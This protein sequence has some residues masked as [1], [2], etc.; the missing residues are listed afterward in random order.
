[1]PSTWPPTGKYLLCLLLHASSCLVSQCWASRRVQ[2]IWEARASVSLKQ[3][4]WSAPEL[5]LK[6]LG[7]EAQ[8]IKF[9]ELASPVFVKRN[10]KGM[11]LSHKAELWLCSSW[12]ML[13]LCNNF[14]KGLTAF[15][16]REIL[17]FIYCCCQKFAF[18]DA[19]L[20]ILSHVLTSVVSFPKK[21]LHRRVKRVNMLNW[22]VLLFVADQSHF[23]IFAYKMSCRSQICLPCTFGILKRLFLFW[24]EE[25]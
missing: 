18:V 7:I 15:D 10:E 21:N 25:Y 1:M 12:E 13:C 5:S 14:Q 23:L 22:T 4:C 9:S 19:M 2:G 6:Q 24:V 17:N 20:N 8:L 16:G 11:A 3:T